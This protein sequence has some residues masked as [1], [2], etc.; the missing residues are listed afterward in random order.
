M[1][2]TSE[3][4]EAVKGYRMGL[5]AAQAAKESTLEKLQK[6]KGSEGYEADVAEAEKAHTEKVTEL[7]NRYRPIVREAIGKMYESSEK[8]TAEPPTEEEIRTLTLL[9][10]RE[11][12]TRDEAQAIANSLT[13]GGAVDVF[14]ENIAGRGIM[15]VTY[16]RVSRV[17]VSQAKE[18]IRSL[19]NLA[20][21]T[22]QMT[23]IG[24]GAR[25]KWALSPAHHPDAD[26]MGPRTDLFY[27]DRDF[28]DVDA[29]LEWASGGAD[30]SALWNALN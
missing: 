19:N 27:V 2:N 23:E 1:S 4:F 15:G 18:A 12:L 26:P 24:A 6:Y 25:A 20:V 8:I 16:S 14:R 11:N 17:T 13:T 10:M 30:I 21:K 5:R 7:Q 3:L 29:M 22:L 28:P 9:K